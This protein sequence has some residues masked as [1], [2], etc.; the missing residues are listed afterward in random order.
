MTTVYQYVGYFTNNSIAS[1]WFIHNIMSSIGRLDRKHDFTCSTHPRINIETSIFYGNSFRPEKLLKIDFVS[2]TLW[3][4]IYDDTIDEIWSNFY[5]FREYVHSPLTDS[6]FRGPIP[7]R[8]KI[9]FEVRR[10]EYGIS[11]YMQGIFVVHGS[12]T[13]RIGHTFVCRYWIPNSRPKIFM[14]G[15]WAGFANTTVFFAKKALW[16]YLLQSV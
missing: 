9:D 16:V 3:R 13:S 12:S 11:E 5:S 4:L 10:R 6:H 14:R 7:R 2:H 15:L 8:G 1:Y